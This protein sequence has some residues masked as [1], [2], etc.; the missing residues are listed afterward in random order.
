MRCTPAAGVITRT[1][2]H[3][4]CEQK[5]LPLLLARERLSHYSRL[6]F[7]VPFIGFPFMSSHPSHA[8]G[9]L[10]RL[11]AS[12]CWTLALALCPLSTH[13]SLSAERTH[14]ADVFVSLGPTHC[15]NTS[16]YTTWPPNIQRC[17]SSSTFWV[18]LQARPLN[19]QP[20]C[21]Q[22]CS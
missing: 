5:W 15:D 14:A 17:F 2:K 12:R 22:P 18:F 7:K 10:R 9:H 8:R 4:S 11:R 20:F 16:H 1:T 21:L 6:H 19:C 13:D 3:A